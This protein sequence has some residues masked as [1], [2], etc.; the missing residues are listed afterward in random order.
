MSRLTVGDIITRGM[1]G[2]LDVNK[3]MNG[4][5]QCIIIRYLTVEDNQLS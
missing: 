1:V 2:A 3:D 4:T 5:K